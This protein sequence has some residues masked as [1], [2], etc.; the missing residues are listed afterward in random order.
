M[1]LADELQDDPHVE[2][3]ES[4]SSEIDEDNN[5][6]NPTEGEKSELD[7]EEIQDF[8]SRYDSKKC[9]LLKPE[10]IRPGRERFEICSEMVKYSFINFFLQII[11]KSSLLILGRNC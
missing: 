7:D 2:M 11:L 6:R 1:P 10:N 3:E 5:Q 8:I 9:D 4:D